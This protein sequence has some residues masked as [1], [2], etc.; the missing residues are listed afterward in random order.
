[1]PQDRFVRLR[2]FRVR[3]PRLIS[4]PT[5]DYARSTV[6]TEDFSLGP[7]GQ[8]IIGGFSPVGVDVFNFPQERRNDTFQF[9]DTLR[10][11]F[12]GKGQHSLAFGTDI[13][14]VYLDSDLPRNSRPLVTFYGGNCFN[15]S[16]TLRCKPP[17][18]HSLWILPQPA[19]QPDFL[20][21]WSR[22]EKMRQSI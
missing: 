12:S 8:V 11:Q 7:V 9:A 4:S 22:R 3:N 13:R 16:T 6:N 10:M 20:N 21:H 14:R 5:V 15:V 18:L 1:M 2:Q 17:D 19:R